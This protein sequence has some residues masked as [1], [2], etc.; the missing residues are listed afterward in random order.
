M[1]K[2]KGVET[3]TLALFDTILFRFAFRENDFIDGE[4]NDHP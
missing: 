2:R 4:I 1:L 3:H